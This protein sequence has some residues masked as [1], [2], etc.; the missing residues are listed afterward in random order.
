MNLKS[1]MSIRSCVVYVIAVVVSWIL[2]ATVWGGTCGLIAGLSI[3]RDTEY[4]QKVAS[5]LEGRGISS[6]TDTKAA[7]AA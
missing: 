4:L 5:F 6:Q 1:E 7:K 3:S 2:L